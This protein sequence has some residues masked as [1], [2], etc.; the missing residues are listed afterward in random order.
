MKK[1][2]ILFSFLSLF[3]FSCSQDN[4]CIERIAVPDNVTKNGNV[5]TFE[6][7]YWIDLPCD[8]DFTEFNKVS[9]V[10]KNFSYNLVDYNFIANTGNNTSKL[11][12]EVILKNNNSFDVEGLPIFI[13]RKDGVEISKNYIDNTNKCT[14][15][16]ANASCS[17]IY[18]KETSLDDEQTQSLEFVS[19]KFL[20]PK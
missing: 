20:L 18:N 17:F 4:G 3:I 16:A 13:M 5:F 9:E 2:V 10:L 8:Y 12:F 6:P 11:Q 1:I 19:V 14:V 15:I 7:S